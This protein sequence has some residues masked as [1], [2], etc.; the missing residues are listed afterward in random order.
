V[1]EKIRWNPPSGPLGRLSSAAAA[2]AEALLPS[3]PNLRDRSRDLPAPPSFAAALRAG[4]TVAVIAEIKRRS[5]SKGTINA[6]I[7]AAERAAV[8]V[9][10]GASALSVLTEPSEFGGATQDL[11]DVAG[12]VR[13][14]LLKKDFHVA[15]V[16]VWE[17]RSCGAS[18]ILFIAR[19]LAPDR[20]P[21]LVEEAFRAGLEVLVEI[22]SEDELDRALATDATVIGVNARDLET[23]E[24]EPWVTARLIPQIPV[25]RVRVAESG[26]SVVSDV[27][28]A[29]SLGAD[30][31]LIGSSLSSAADPRAA[32][33]A[34][35]GVARR[36]A[37]G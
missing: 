16:Q 20:L 15:E 24:I 7:R 13:V 6:E 22:R 9:A 30:A 21:A 12:A 14:P 8:Y 23:L 33:R 4:G 35:G 5:P 2:R 25:E 32:L 17:A 26:M 3:L 27:E 31:V 11:L 36:G 19:A 28:R 34:L 18:A 29:A 37:G 1:Q 10:A